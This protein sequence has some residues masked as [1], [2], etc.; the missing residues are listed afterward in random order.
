MHIPRLSL[1]AWSLFLLCLLL[2]GRL[3]ASAEDQV[4]AAVTAAKAWVA[5][6][7]AGKYEDSYD[8]TCVETRSQFPQDQWVAVL[9][10][11]RA[12]WGPVVDREQLSHVYKSDGVPGLEGECVVLTYKTDFKNM[13]GVT[14]IVVMK[15]QDG[16]WLAAGYN[17]R[18]IP[19][20][21]APTPEPPPDVT[22]RHTD[23]HAHPQ[24][25]TPGQ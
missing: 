23:E 25:Q 1:A 9:K 20:P 12:P 2:P 13:A 10:A 3:P 16:R 4:D 24:V 11:L 21:N 17:A 6:I 18:V 22:E 14:E 15:W 8:S 5:V 7:D 19:D